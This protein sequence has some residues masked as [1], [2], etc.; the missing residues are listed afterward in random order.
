M[1]SPSIGNLSAIA[2]SI[3]SYALNDG[4]TLTVPEIDAKLEKIGHFAPGQ[5][6]SKALKELQAAGLVERWIR[7][8]RVKSAKQL[9]LIQDER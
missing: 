6:L 9:S 8:F 3:W 1:A 4:V 5:D 7:G 2:L